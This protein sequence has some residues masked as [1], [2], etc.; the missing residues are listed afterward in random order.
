MMMD[1]YKVSAPGLDK[2][3]KEG[4]FSITVSERDSEVTDRQEMALVLLMAADK[5]RVTLTGPLTVELV[6]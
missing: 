1:T 2:K 6:A 5:A 3:G 4:V